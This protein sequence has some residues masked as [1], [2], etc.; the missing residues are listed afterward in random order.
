[1]LSIEPGSAVGPLVFDVP[2]GRGAVWCAQRLARD[3]STQDRV[4][5]EHAGQTEGERRGFLTRT[6]RTSYA[7]RYEFLFFRVSVFDFRGFSTEWRLFTFC[8]PAAPRALILPIG[9]R[10]LHDGLSA[11][12]PWSVHECATNTSALPL[13]LP[14][15]LFVRRKTRK[16]FLVLFF[17][18]EQRAC[19]AGCGKTLPQLACD[20]IPQP[21]TDRKAGDARAGS[22]R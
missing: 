6:R 22:A 16:I 13:P 17:K 8:P 19:R 15:Q 18:K 10:A 4:A 5:P 2:R 3:A 12:P 9:A 1:M 7:K 20:L 14:P 11:T 21:L